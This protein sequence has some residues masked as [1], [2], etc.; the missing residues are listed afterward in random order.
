MA[1]PS[2][3]KKL[4]GVIVRKSD[5]NKA[6]ICCWLI[7]SEAADT[8][9]PRGH[10]IVKCINQTGPE[11]TVKKDLIDQANNLAAVLQPR[12]TLAMWREK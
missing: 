2:K 9:I 6:P 8:P 7:I 1:K 11:D 12:V 10:V 3:R 4:Y 5:E